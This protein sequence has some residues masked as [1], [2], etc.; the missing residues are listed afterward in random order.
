MNT[1]KCPT[2]NAPAKMTWSGLDLVAESGDE[3]LASKHYEY[4][5]NGSNMMLAVSGLPEI[6]CGVVTEY[7][8][9]KIDNINQIDGIIL[10]GKDLIEICQSVHE[11]LKAACANSGEAQGVSD[12]LCY[13]SGEPCK[14]G[15][16]GLCKESF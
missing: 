6:I 14:Y 2:C 10:Y 3:T 16:S 5:P 12:G 1:T 9:E 4:R 13:K 7:Y 8:G 15:C 11:A